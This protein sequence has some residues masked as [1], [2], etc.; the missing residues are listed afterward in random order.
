MHQAQQHEWNIANVRPSNS[1]LGSYVSMTIDSNAA[2]STYGD[3]YIATF[4]NATGD[5]VYIHG[6]DVDGT[7]SGLYYTF[8]APVTID[9]DGSVG[10]WSDISLMYNGT[11]AVP[12][13]SYLN[14]SA[15]GTLEG[16]KYAWVESGD[17]SSEDDWEYGIIPSDDPVR[18]HRT[19][20]VAHSS[21]NIGRNG[22]ENADVA[23]GFAGTYFDIVYRAKEQ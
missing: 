16:L 13:V 15:V 19:N 9:T 7:G 4:Q 12:Y 1:Y 20:I 14:S 17:G 11:T 6:H 23:I 8:D 3:L 10:A 18:D 22:G 2:S 21:V 5:L